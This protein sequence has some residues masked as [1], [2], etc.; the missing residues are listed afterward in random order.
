MIFAISLRHIRTLILGGLALLCGCR[1]ALPP[2]KHA[3]IDSCLEASGAWNYRSG[4]CERGATGPVDLIMV[5][6]SAHMMAVY[7]DGRLVREFRVALGRGGVGPKVQQG[8]GKVPEGRYRITGHNPK[9]AY[10][11]SLRV[12]YPTPLQLAAARKVGI[13]PGGDNMIH[14][15][16]NDMPEIG[17]LHTMYDWTEGC[18]AVTNREIEWLYR[19]VPNGIAIEIR[20]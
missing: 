3:A 18:V 1:T 14:G 10:H 9:S 8:D 20:G 11:L 2:D 7:R 19:N 12:G 6:K 4:A 15:L 13:N 17:S 5:E 16:P